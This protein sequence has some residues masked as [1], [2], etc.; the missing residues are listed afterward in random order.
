MSIKDKVAIVGVGCSK[1]GIHY[2]KGP[3]EMII[4]A[5]HEAY[6]DAGIEAKEIQAA[7]L[8]TYNSGF[9]GSILAD[10]L[11]LFDIP[12]TRVENACATGTEAF[13]NA[14]FGVA[15][16][17]Y[18]IA[19]A[20][21]VEKMRDVSGPLGGAPGA[22]PF[23]GFGRTMAGFFGML[24]NS[25]FNEF[26]INEE[27][28]AKVAVKNHRNGALHPKAHFQREIDLKTAL[29]A[30][31]V[32]HPLGLFDC[33]PT[34]DGAAAIILVKKE[35]AKKFRDDPIYLK[36]LGIAISRVGTSLLYNQDFK[37]L[38]F[39]ATQCAADQAYQ[40][41]GINNPRKEINLAEVH[42][43][44]T[45]T[46]IVNYEDLGFCKKG[47]GGEFISSGVSFLEGELPINPSGG[48]KSF[49][50]PIGATG[51]RMI[52]EVVKQL[53]GRADGGQVK[54]AEMGLTHNLGAGDAG[55]IAAVTILG[56]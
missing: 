50:H 12:V 7:W 16:G 14:A 55:V 47:E 34:T 43:C 24:A 42:D 18:D 41:A 1:F 10:P 26:H 49:G 22:H 46:E 29:N 37:F 48:L 5:V 4:E 17:M 11:G 53:Q 40:Q 54:K 39:P 6:K 52:Y 33:C 13:R 45:I 20:V 3:N 36:G 9:T 35:L 15:S 56:N 51:C 30:P 44:F 8:G 32:A 19:L 25:Y 28:L 38:G 21:G 31:K 27:T 2:D 23:F